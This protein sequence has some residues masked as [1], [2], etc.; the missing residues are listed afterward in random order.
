MPDRCKVARVGKITMMSLCRR[1]MVHPGIFDAAPGLVVVELVQIGVVKRDA[2]S[3]SLPATR[4]AWLKSGYFARCV[5]GSEPVIRAIAAP[6]VHEWRATLKM[7]SHRGQVP[8]RA[9]DYLAAAILDQPVRH[10]KMSGVLGPMWKLAHGY[11]PDVCMGCRF[12][13][14]WINATIKETVMGIQ[15]PVV[16]HP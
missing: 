5:F 16:I 12:D 1:E 7:I 8:V 3:R 9:I 4:A 15:S 10:H 14:R 6:V 2:R 11:L 13:P